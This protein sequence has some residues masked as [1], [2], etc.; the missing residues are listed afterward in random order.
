MST[1]SPLAAGL[2]QLCPNCGKAPVF[3]SYLRFCEVCPACGADFRIADAGDGPAV[4]VMFLVGALVVPFALVLQFGAKAP[5][6]V[7]LTLALAAAIGL[8]LALLPPFK[9]TMFA[10]Q[11]RHQAAEAR[12][13]TTEEG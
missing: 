4:F 9:A 5:E 3:S 10:L 2:R 7:V 1:P 12:F 8:C 13:D 6:W 11:W